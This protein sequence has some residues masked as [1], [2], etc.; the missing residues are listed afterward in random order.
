MGCLLPLSFLTLQRGSA[1]PDA[2]RRK[3][4]RSVQ[5]GMRRGAPHDSRQC[6]AQSPV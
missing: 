5:K 1:V 2:L 4:T 3:S 6:A